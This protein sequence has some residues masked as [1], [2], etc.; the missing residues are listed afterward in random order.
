MGCP[1]APREVEA[2]KIGSRVAAVIVALPLALVIV[3]LAPWLVGDALAQTG[4]G[5]VDGFQTPD[6]PPETK[7]GPPRN[8]ADVRRMA[9]ALATKKKGYADVSG[10]KGVPDT[11]ERPYERN[12]NDCTTGNAQAA[13]MFNDECTAEYG[14]LLGLRSDS[15]CHATVMYQGK[16]GTKFECDFTPQSSGIFIM[17]NRDTQV[18]EAFPD[19]GESVDPAYDCV[20]NGANTRALNPFGGGGGGGM[21]D[22]M[23]QLMLLKL[24]QDMFNQQQNPAAPP[25]VSPGP[26]IA[27]PINT[28]TPTATITPA[29]T[30]TQTACATPSTHVATL[31]ALVLPTQAPIA[32]EFSRSPG[33]DFGLVGA[34]VDVLKRA[35]PALNPPPSNPDRISEVLDE[36]IGYVCGLS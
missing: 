36:G 32:K 26:T 7:S 34:D 22:T 27:P 35:D 12:R 3:G 17:N 13:C 24:L 9:Y 28:P 10:K 23:M 8:C 21:M 33:Q 5:P 4:G 15:A 20:M 19:A 6:C 25:G 14:Q 29:A 30:A 16:D 31:D 1:Q 11:M 2:T 18:G